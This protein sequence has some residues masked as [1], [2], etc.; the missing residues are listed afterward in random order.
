MCTIVILRRP[1]HPWPLLVATNRDEIKDRP[2]RPPARH[3]PDRPQVVGG[4]DKTAGGSWLGVNDQG[5]VAGV[6]NRKG[7]LGPERGKLSRGELVL[8]ALDHSDASAAATAIS[9]EDPDKYRSFNLVV[10]DRKNA[11]WLRNLGKAPD[12][13]RI[14]NQG[15]HAIEI[16]ELGQGVSMITAHDRND[17]LSPRIKANL[18]RFEAAQAPDPRTGAW[19]S[20]Q[21]ILAS[22]DYAEADGPDAAMTVVTDFGFGTISSSLIALPGLP[23]SARE[24]PSAPVWLF[25]PGPPDTTLYERVAF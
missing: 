25:A 9:H 7:S 21:E 23:Q 16:F 13:P 4:Q 14:S 11:F 12:S 3:W 8:K 15:P 20:W 1:G 2:W 24:R 5:L 18:P 10:G 17:P 19:G 22:R 6:L